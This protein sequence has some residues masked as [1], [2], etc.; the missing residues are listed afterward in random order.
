VGYIINVKN[1]KKGISS[2][3]EK[4]LGDDLSRT[5][6]SLGWISKEYNTQDQFGVWGIDVGLPKTTL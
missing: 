5:L 3:G 6:I 4:E 2:S 1:L